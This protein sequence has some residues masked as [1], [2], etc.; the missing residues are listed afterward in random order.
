M[1]GWEESH[2]STTSSRFGTQDQNDSS[3]LPPLRVD[4][5]PP[6]ELQAATIAT[7]TRRTPAA[8]PNLSLI[9]SSNARPDD[10]GVILD[11]ERSQSSPETSGLSIEPQREDS[12][13]R[14]D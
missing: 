2:K 7:H 10:M 3:T 14:N 5:L 6:L 13:N 1:S 12:L 4:L 9:A 8:L 11:C